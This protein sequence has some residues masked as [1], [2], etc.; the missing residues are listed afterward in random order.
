MFRP[1]RPLPG[2]PVAA[3][4][5]SIPWQPGGLQCFPRDFKQLQDRMPLSADRHPSLWDTVR[6]LGVP[7][8]TRWHE[9]LSVQPANSGKS[10]LFPFVGH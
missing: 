6:E 1:L 4:P 5:A 2:A 10:R 7:L 8:G 9:I 3:R